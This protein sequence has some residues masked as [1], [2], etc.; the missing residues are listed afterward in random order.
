M[1]TFYKKTTTPKTTLVRRTFGT[2]RS[3][4]KKTETKVAKPK[5]REVDE[6]AVQLPVQEPTHQNTYVHKRA[7]TTLSVLDDLLHEPVSAKQPQNHY[8]AEDEN[9][10]FE[11]EE[12][13]QEFDGISDTEE[14]K[15]LYSEAIDYERKKAKAIQEHLKMLEKEREDERKA[16]EQEIKKLKHELHRTVPIQDNKFFSLSKQLRDAVKEIETIASQEGISLDQIRL[17]STTAPQ[18]TKPEASPIFSAQ[19]KVETMPLK[20]VQPEKKVEVQ[21]AKAEETSQQEPEEAKKSLPKKKML[22]TGATA[23]V[24]LMIISG[25]IIKTITSEPTVDEDLVKQYLSTQTGQVQGA[26]TANSTD[27]AQA[28]NQSAK[29]DPSQSEVTF[30][31]SVWEEF[32]DPSFGVVLQYPKNAVKPI[33]TESN[34]TFIRKTG[35]LFKVQRIETALTL[36]EYWKQIKATSLNYTVTEDKFKG[37]PALKL[38]LEDL[39]DYPGDRFLVKEGNFIYDIWYA[40]PSN[41]FIKDDVMRAEKM[42]ASLS[43]LGTK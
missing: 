26:Q 35:Y 37:K 25:T 7:A 36:E 22:I 28:Q 8:E 19:P 43:I 16:L 30:E 24:I 32:N 21:P 1:P 41:S 13:I 10:V 9:A 12:E 29:V 14:Q 34:I 6:E 3:V 11:D 42:L 27:P 33:R 15:E 4:V 38:E 39:A 40:T 20:P 31:E 17:S 5:I 18:E 23:I 2:R